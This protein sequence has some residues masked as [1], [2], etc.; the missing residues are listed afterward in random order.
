MDIALIFEA[1][2]YILS[3]YPE[4][5]DRDRLLALLEKRSVEIGK[6]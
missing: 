5:E 3:R 1:L 4:S 6:Y 2:A